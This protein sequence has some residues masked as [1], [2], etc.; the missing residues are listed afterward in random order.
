MVLRTNCIF[1]EVNSE[2]IFLKNLVIKNLFS[3]NSLRWK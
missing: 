2:K 1:S 3:M